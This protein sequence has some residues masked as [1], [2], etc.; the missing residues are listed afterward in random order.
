MSGGP[1]K[2]DVGELQDTATGLRT[3]KGDY[4]SATSDRESASSSFGFDEISGAVEEFVSSWSDKRK[5]QIADLE[6]AHQGLTAI[7]DNYEQLDADGVTQL[8]D[9]GG[10]P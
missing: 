9:D 4:E 1:Y 3:L 2:Y 5:E 7:I 8:Q 10:A 6:S